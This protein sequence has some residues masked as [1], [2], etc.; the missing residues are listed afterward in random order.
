MKTILTRNQ[1]KISSSHCLTK[2]GYETKP[3]L[4]ANSFAQKLMS[5]GTFKTPSV[6]PKMGKSNFGK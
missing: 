6:E 4:A 2:P 5:K 3:N 1:G